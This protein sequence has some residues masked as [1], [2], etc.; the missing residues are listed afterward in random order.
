LVLAWMVTQ[1]NWYF[2]IVSQ[3]GNEPVATAPGS[4]IR[5]FEGGLLPSKIS[6]IHFRVHLTADQHCYSS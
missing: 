2:K 3:L 5:S 1:G 6:A 4:V